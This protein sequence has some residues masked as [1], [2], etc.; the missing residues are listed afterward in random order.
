VNKS[1][2]ILCLFGIITRIV[3]RVSSLVM[4]DFKTHT[5][6]ESMVAVIFV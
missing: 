6:N 2:T 4:R 1:L 5:N 3:F